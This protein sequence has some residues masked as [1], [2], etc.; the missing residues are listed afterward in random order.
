[1]TGAVV[2]AAGASVRLGQPKQLVVRDGET[3]VHRAARV[4]L[5]AGCSPVVVVEGAV[6]LGEALK[7]LRVEVV[8]C[9]DWQAGQGASLKRGVAS[10]GARCEGVVVLLVDQLRVT[11]ADVRALV[12]A[13]GQVAAAEYEGVLG[14]PAR[15]S[16]ESVDVLRGLEDGEGARGWLARNRAQVTRVPMS[17]AAIDLDVPADLS[18]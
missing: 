16:G 11:A 6:G 14:V 7:D 1:M 12:D 13:P 3:L 18:R 8:R 2:L 5:E 4:L 15:F 17:H 9:A 10:L